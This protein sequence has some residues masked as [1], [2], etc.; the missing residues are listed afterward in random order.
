MRSR[1]ALLAA[2]LL[3]LGSPACTTPLLDAPAKVRHHRVTPWIAP[4]W[5]WSSSEDGTSAS[6]STIF[7]LV[8]A[9]REEGRSTRRALPFYW[10]GEDVPF[11][12]TTFVFPLYYGRTAV[13][14]R[15]RF[16]SLLYGFVDAPE[17]RA[18][19][20][21]MPFFRMERS[22]VDDV[23]SSGFLF[24]Y[25]WRHDDARNDV[26]LIPILGLA[27]LGRF[28]WGFPPEGETVG[29][30]GRAGARRFELLNLLGIVSLLGY[31][32][33][34]DRRELR[35]LT[36]FS[37]EMLSPIRSWRG[38][39]DDPFVRE[40]LFPLYMNVRDDDG[41]WLYVGPLWGR[42]TDRAAERTTDWWLAGLLSRTEKP[43]GV[44]WRVAGLP[45][46][47]P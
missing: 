31:D 8:G 44:T 11:S 12:E 22:K 21:L 1:D 30:E 26:T 33:V 20:A 38:R 41:G 3:A 36:L 16:Y 23:W 7:G 18:D 39:G 2:A 34:G 14:E 15:R 9:D 10:H 40:W 28:Q 5:T 4:L 32:D 29:A 37:S 17:S 35:L 25:D 6:W 24:V 47:G 43:E 27:H 45:I 46:A 19:Y 13:E 42:T